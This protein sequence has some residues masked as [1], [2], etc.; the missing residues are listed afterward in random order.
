MSIIKTHDKYL[1]GKTDKYNIILEPL[2]DDHLN[3]L[4]KWCADSE[5]L[6]WT[7]GGEDIVRS[8]D[9]ETVHEI[10][11]G[12]SKNNFCFLINANDIPIGECWLQRMNIEY[13]KE[14]YQDN[15][16]VRRIDMAIGEKEYW[17]KGIGTELIK[18]LVDF[19]FQT[20]RVDILHCLCEDYNIRSKRIWEKNDFRLV[21]QEK[22]AQPQRGKFQCHY[23]LTKDEYFKNIELFPKLA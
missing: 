14:M 6:Y 10:Y 17:N 18:I 13:V 22:L 11:G 23:R 12:I 19:A 21:L 5:V 2:C 20:E 9:K 7:E 15:M 16:D 1:Y 3:L 8:Y 4:Y